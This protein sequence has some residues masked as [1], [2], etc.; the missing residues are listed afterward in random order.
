MRKIIALVSAAAIALAVAGVS[1]AT[2]DYSG[3]ATVAVIHKDDPGAGPGGNV[4][5]PGNTIAGPKID[6]GS[7]YSDAYI[8]VTK[9]DGKTFDWAF[10]SLGNETND[11]GLVIVKGGP[12]SAVYTY[13]FTANPS[14]D[15]GDT[16]L[17]A[18]M[19]PNNGKDYGISHIQFCFDPK[20]GGDN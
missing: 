7:N 20:G 15:D 11:M 19:N 2:H 5:C 10:T 18:P 1:L 3:T 16:G 17:S 13:D 12:A 8:K 6:P 9:Y 14:F 4:Y